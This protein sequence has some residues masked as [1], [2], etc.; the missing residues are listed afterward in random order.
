M[1][2]TIG[3]RSTAKAVVRLEHGDRVARGTGRD[4]HAGQRPHRAQRRAAGQQ[5]AIGLDRP[6]VGLDRR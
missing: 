3:M 5:H 1:S 6:R 2:K 4:A